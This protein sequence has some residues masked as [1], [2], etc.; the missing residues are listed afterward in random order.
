MNEVAE[1][2]FFSGSP[3]QCL[4]TQNAMKNSKENAH[5]EMARDEHGGSREEVPWINHYAFDVAMMIFSPSFS[6][7]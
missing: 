2:E 7:N 3:L 6:Q 4:R 5:C 1:G